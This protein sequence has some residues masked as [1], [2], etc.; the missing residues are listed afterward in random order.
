MSSYSTNSAKFLFEKP[1]VEEGANQNLA[2]LDA[3]GRLLM[4]RVRDASIVEWD[5]IID[6]GA[7]SPAEKRLH[8][9]LKTFDA[10]QR[11]AIRE[12]LPQIVD[13]TLDHL[14]WTLEQVKWVDV[15]VQTEKGTVPSIRDVSD[16][17]AGEKYYWIP[18]FSEQRYDKTFYN[19]VELT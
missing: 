3:F 18:K 5:G 12:L 15:A 1:P 4:A 7:T 14:L 13:T 8:E 6:G 2:A 11:D 16:G 19:E 9:L 17:L 10:Q